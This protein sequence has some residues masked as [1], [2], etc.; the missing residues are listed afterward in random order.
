[1]L[2]LE[3]KDCRSTIVG[4]HQQ[5]EALIQAVGELD[6]QFKSN[7]VDVISLADYRQRDE[8][9]SPVSYDIES[10]TTLHGHTVVD[11][12]RFEAS[13]YIGR[14]RKGD[15]TITI[16]PRYGNDIFNYIVGYA[17]NVYIPDGASDVSFGHQ[18]NSY[19]QIALLWRAML[20]KALRNAQIPK[21]YQR[22]TKNQRYFRGRLDVTKHLRTN[23]FDS[24]RFYCT[25][26]KLSM[27]NVINRTVRTVYKILCLKG[28]SDVVGEFE[29]YDKRL[30]AFGV[31]DDVDLDD[32][33][34]VRYT[35]LTDAY[36]PMMAISAIILNHRNASDSK[37]SDEK[38]FS[39]FIDLAELWELYLLRVLQRHLPKDYCVYSLN[40]TKGDYLLRGNMREIRPDILIEREGTVVAIIDAK[41][42]GY[43]RLGST[44]M[45]GVS[46]EDLYQ[47]ATYLYHYGQPDCRVVGILSSPTHDEDGDIHQL[48]RNCSHAIGLVNLSIDG[49]SVAEIRKEEQRYAERIMQAINS[50]K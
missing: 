31:L 38:G 41:Y 37:A 36:R 13:H 32:I 7:S 46:R 26:E 44:S 42:K 34:G 28:L 35:R 20:E 8:Y 47:M 16:N 24:S 6:A 40:K 11:K 4:Y 29:N 14:Y 50:K 3:L 19:W 49:K 1:M 25:Y 33:R 21:Q 15:V 45:Q 2:N 23:M 30:A 10:Y 17:A 5:P 39:Y 22:V 48:S 27:D 43:Q 12:C 9:E 18:A